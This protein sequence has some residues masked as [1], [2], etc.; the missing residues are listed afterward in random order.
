MNNLTIKEKLKNLPRI[1]VESF[2][3]NE[4]RREVIR[5]DFYNF[6]IDNYSFFITT[7]EQDAKKVFYGCDGLFDKEGKH[8]LLLTSYLETIK[9][10]YETTNEEYAIFVEDD[11]W[12]ES[13]RYWNFTWD[14]FVK[15]LPPDWEIIH[16]G[17]IHMMHPSWDYHQLDNTIKKC[18]H[19]TPWLMSLIRRPYAKVLIDRY[20][21]GENIYDLTP[22]SIPEIRKEDTIAEALIYM[23]TEKSYRFFLLSENPYYQIHSSIRTD[24]NLCFG[25]ETYPL[26]TITPLFIKK[27]IKWWEEIGSQKTISELMSLNS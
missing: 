24:Y 1:Y 16:L 9:H 10:W 21:K 3:K 18:H 2:E 23:C 12:F 19:P 4:R 14:D 11:V 20:I 25:S 15:Y 22:P 5:S 7:P 27:V 13:V 8:K 6:G 26:T 17:T